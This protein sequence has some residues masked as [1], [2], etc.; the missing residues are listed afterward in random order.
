MNT[1]QPLRP[2]TQPIDY[3]SGYTP[4]WLTKAR[5]EIL[6]QALTKSQNQPTEQTSSK[7]KLLGKAAFLFSLGMLL[8]TL[9]ARTLARPTL[10]PVDWKAYAK[11][12]LGIKTVNAANNAFDFKPPPWLNGIQ[13]VAAITPLTMGL[14]KA[15]LKQFVFIAP[16]VAAVVQS[17]VILNKKATPVLKE[18]FNIPPLA[19]QLAISTGMIGLGAVASHKLLKNLGMGAAAVMTCARGCSPGSIICLSEAGEMLGTLKNWWH[20][21]TH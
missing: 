18:K 7:T 10:I 16:L 15:S 12:I 20:D 14:S 1:L 4:P 13:A 19:T 6:Q 9:P 3:A 21:K 2:T 17:A 5:V 11:I 8:R